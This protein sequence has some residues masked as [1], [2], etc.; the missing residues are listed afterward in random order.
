MPSLS[1]VLVLASAV[2]VVRHLQGTYIS[3]HGRDCYRRRV[4]AQGGSCGF[5]GCPSGSACDQKGSGWGLSCRRF[6]RRVSQVPG[7]VGLVC[8]CGCGWRSC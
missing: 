1:L 5:V 3:G 4:V 8:R 2:S 7:G 6:V